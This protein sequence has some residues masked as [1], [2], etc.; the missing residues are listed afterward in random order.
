MPPTYTDVPITSVE[1]IGKIGLKMGWVEKESEESMFKGWQPRFLI[2]TGWDEGEAHLFYFTKETDKEASGVLFINDMKLEDPK[3][4]EPT[5][6]QLQ[7]SQRRFRFRCSDEIMAR[8]WRMAIAEASQNGVHKCRTGVGSMAWI[9]Q[10]HSKTCEACRQVFSATKAKHHCRCCGRVFCDGCSNNPKLMLEPYPNPVRCCRKCHQNQTVQMDKKRLLDER[11]AAFVNNHLDLLLAGGSFGDLDRSDLGR[12]MCLDS[13]SGVSLQ[14]R[15]LVVVERVN[16]NNL[17]A[18]KVSRSGNRLKAAT[19]R[20]IES[21]SQLRASHVANAF[22]PAEMV[23]NVGA[24]TKGGV[25]VVT[26]V[27]KDLVNLTQNLTDHVTG[28]REWAI[29][30]R[31]IK[32]VS[33]C[34][35]NPTLDRKYGP[36]TARAFRVSYLEE[37]EA[38]ASVMFVAESEEEKRQ[39]LEALTEMS[40]LMRDG[41][42]EKLVLQK[43]KETLDRNVRDNL[44]KRRSSRNARV[45][46]ELASKEGKEDAE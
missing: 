27:G 6:F 26:H 1:E 32:G 31:D 46:E 34:S 2:L 23:K 33:D 28:P 36:A 45:N 17:L 21:I 11:S 35:G 38:E 15:R 44:A 14:H 41:A 12:T 24:V 18:D 10:K 9:M 30:V 3:A 42:T 29:L 20:G 5:V 25:G 4:T 16:E 19:L 7:G 39:W 43:D 40:C 22:K 8:G 37:G 13:G